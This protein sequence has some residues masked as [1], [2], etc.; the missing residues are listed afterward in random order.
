MKLKFN[1]DFAKQVLQLPD[2]GYLNTRDM[3]ILFKYSRPSIHVA[4]KEGLLPAPVTISDRENATTK[5]KVNNFNKGR[6]YPRKTDINQWRVADAVVR[7]FDLA[8]AY[9]LDLAGAIVEKMAYNAQRADHKR[10]A[11][12]SV[13][14]KR[15]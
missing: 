2:K 9:N 8:G 11:R 12:D 3:C 13:G 10:D 15:Y 5:A 7:I 14:G 4:A 6:Q 1:I